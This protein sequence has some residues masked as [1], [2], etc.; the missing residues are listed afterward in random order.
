MFTIYTR[1]GGVKV[2]LLYKSLSNRVLRIFTCVYLF[3]KFYG[4]IFEKILD[5]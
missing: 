4:L 2:N 5:L 1:I 3:P